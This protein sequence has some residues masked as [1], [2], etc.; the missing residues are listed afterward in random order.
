MQRY[1]PFY[2]A[3]MLVAVLLLGL[4]APASAQRS[5]DYEEVIERDFTVRSGQTLW[6]DTERGS[7]RVRGASGNQVHVTVL[8]GVD[9]VSEDR[10]YDLFDRFEVDFRETS[11]GLSIEGDYDGDRGWRRNRLHVAFEITLPEDFNVDVQTAGGSIDVRGLL[12]EAN[13]DTSGGSITAIDIGGPISLDTSGG[14]VTAEN[15][16][17]R[18]LL[19]TSGGSIT[20]R[21]IKGDVDCDTSGGSITVD[22]AEGDVV[23]HTSGGSIRLDNIY[24]TVE[25]E[26]S[27]GSITADLAMA[28]DGPMKL[29]TSGGSISL[30]LAD[31]TRA[32]IDARASGGRVRSDLPVLVQGEISRSRLRGT[33]NGGGPLLTLRTHGG[34]IKINRR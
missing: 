4:A 28:P 1:Q 15:I 26:T 23:A 19:N 5:Y 13:L 3:L 25:A 2:G 8:K 18:A 16:G 7:V 11:S 30:Y 29:E 14:S 34:G 17:G 32:D 33:L 22:G 10:A 31:D 20:A 6:L 24:G 12:G 27:G 9:D 21:D